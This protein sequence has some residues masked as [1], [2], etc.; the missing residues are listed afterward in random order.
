LLVGLGPGFAGPWEGVA[1]GGMGF[2]YF[3][4]PAQ[5]EAQDFPRHSLGEVRGWKVLWGKCSVV[6]FEI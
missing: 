3:F 1:E 6:N 2:L 4:I 5:N